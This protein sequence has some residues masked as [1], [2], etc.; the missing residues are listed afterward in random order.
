VRFYCQGLLVILNPDCQF[1][2]SSLSSDSRFG[3]DH[4]AA[5]SC[6][7]EVRSVGILPFY[8]VREAGI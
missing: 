2:C 3:D 8:S 5:N 7:V 4:R 6:F 1:D